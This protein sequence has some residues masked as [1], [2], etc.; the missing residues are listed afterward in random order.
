MLSNAGAAGQSIEYAT[1]NSMQM[2]V[3]SFSSFSFSF[4]PFAL[5]SWP[6]PHGMARFDTNSLGTLAII[7]GLY[8]FADGS[9]GTHQPRPGPS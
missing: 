8:S 6:G 9:N 1:L 7:S 5:L 4:C 3:S 2:P